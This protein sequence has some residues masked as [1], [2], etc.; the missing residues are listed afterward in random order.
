MNLPATLTFPAPVAPVVGAQSY[1]LL[2][3][4]WREWPPD[5]QTD[6]TDVLDR[7]WSELIRDTA[8][9]G[10]TL[11]PEWTAIV[12]TGPL[13]VVMH[14][15]SPGGGVDHY[16]DQWANEHPD[17]LVVA[18]RQSAEAARFGQGPGRYLKRNS[19]M[20]ARLRAHVTDGGPGS[21]LAFPG[22]SNGTVD[23][24][25]KAT[26]AGLPGTVIPYTE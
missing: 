21:W 24:L 4:G 26:R 11:P 8:P 7:I 15:D 5:R 23:C 9:P 20:V 1:L 6:I 3:T 13:L 18:E 19:H 25:L 22:N 2:V 17:E 16:A 12:P 14:G 10:V